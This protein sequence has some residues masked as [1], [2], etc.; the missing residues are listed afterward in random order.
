MVE[1]AVEA[2]VAVSP[3]GDMARGGGRGLGDRPK[4]MKQFKTVTLCARGHK[5]TSRI[6]VGKGVSLLSTM[7]AATAR[8]MI[9][10]PD[11]SLQVGGHCW[12]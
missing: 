8:Q 7:S 10:A 1:V 6:K 11:G 5:E 9:P 3:A 12:K 4:V 2:D